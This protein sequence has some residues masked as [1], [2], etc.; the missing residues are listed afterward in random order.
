VGLPDLLCLEALPVGLP[1][2]ALPSLGV[3]ALPLAARQ[4]LAAGGTARGVSGVTG[5]AASQLGGWTSARTAGC[6]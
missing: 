1:L 2:R 6:R 3:E 5:V 4:A